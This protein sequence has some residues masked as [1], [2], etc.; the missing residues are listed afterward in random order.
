MTVATA[1]AS[2]AVRHGD[3]YWIDALRC[4][5]RVEA[6]LLLLPDE[7]SFSLS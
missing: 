2:R 4:T 7:Y 6:C 5:N 3:H 1:I